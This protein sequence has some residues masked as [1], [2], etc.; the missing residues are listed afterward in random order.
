MTG[1]QKTK[2]R[3]LKLYACRTYAFYI[4]NWASSIIVKDSSAAAIYGRY[5]FFWVHEQH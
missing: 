3:T 4:D 1:K 2:A 5:L